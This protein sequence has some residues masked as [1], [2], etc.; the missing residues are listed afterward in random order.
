MIAA[1]VLTLTALHRA[2]APWLG[3]VLAQATMTVLVALGLNRLLRSDGRND[4]PAS[5][6]PVGVQGSDVG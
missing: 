5:T 1:Y 6:L 3:Y 2:D 4:G